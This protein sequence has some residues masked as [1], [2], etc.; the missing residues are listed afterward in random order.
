M[1]LRKNMKRAAAAALALS[2]ALSAAA[3]A[4][5]AK[6]YYID[7]GDI[8]VTVTKDGDT[9]VRVGEATKEGDLGVKDDTEVVIKG[10]ENPDK[11]TGNKSGGSA[12]EDTADEAEGQKPVVDAEPGEPAEKTGTE[13]VVWPENVNSGEAQKKDG[14]EPA[15]AEPETPDTQKPEGKTDAD[16]L[17]AST[18]QKPVEKAAEDE[19]DDK[20]IMTFEDNTADTVTKVVSEAVKNVI[21]IIN[22]CTKKDT[23]VTIQDVN[24]DASKDNKAALSVK[25]EG[26]TTLKL[27][28]NNTLRGGQ[29]CAGLEKD[30]EL[31]TGKLTITAEDT[32]SSLNAYGGNG[33]AGIGGGNQKSTSN[34][35]IANGK[36]HAVGG[37]LGAGIGGGGFGGNGE[38][39]ISGGEVTAQGGFWA[40]GIGGGGTQGSGKVTIKNGN[41]TA[42]TNSLAAAI[43]GGN[44][45]SGDVTILD[46]RVTTQLVNKNDPVTGIGGAPNS[47]DKSTVRILG[48]VVDA[49]GNRY[50]SGIGGGSGD[51]QGAEVE[52]G[53]GAQVT[54]KGGKEGTYAG[55]TYGAGAAIGTSGG[56]GGIA[57]KELDVNPSVRVRSPVLP[58]IR[59]LI[60]R[61][62]IHG[63]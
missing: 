25:G 57:G 11:Q 62:S 49:V 24:I 28:G 9:Y 60:R 8:T 16:T 13:L 19:D 46:G 21:K 43:G 52:I 6:E 27:E 29:S 18:E 36:I 53:G 59:S 10:G 56:A 50:G 40:A 54:A 45:G 23:T 4:A 30:D 5:L 47:T 2:V 7:D 34:L 35:E 32:S 12:D 31:S 20:D 17:E 63:H 38:V 44:G 51:A 22:N 61:M 33:G 14:L 48:G 42:K 3:P 41:V 1:R 58:P 15:D 39:T 55:K 37:L 26:D